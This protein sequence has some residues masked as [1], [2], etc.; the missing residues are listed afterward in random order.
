MECA[1]RFMSVIAGDMEGYEEALRT[2]YKADRKRLLL[3]M[4]HWSADA[5]S[6]LLEWAEPV[7]EAV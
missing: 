1:Y 4:Q 2:M 7:F 5:R 6:H 3:H